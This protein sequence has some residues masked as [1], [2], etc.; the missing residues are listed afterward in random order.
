MGMKSKTVS[1]VIAVA[2]VVAIVA[3]SACS[4]SGP[5]EERSSGTGDNGPGSAAATHTSEPIVD[6]RVTD[7]PTQAL[8]PED[9]EVTAPP[10]PEDSAPVSGDEDVEVFSMEGSLAVDFQSLSDITAAS[11]VIIVG[12]V[13][14][15]K[16]NPYQ[17]IPFTVF[18]VRVDQAIKGD[19][20]VDSSTTIVETGGL[21]AG[22]SKEEPGQ[23]GKPAEA[24]FEGV[25]VM[26]VG[27]QWLL[28][29]GPY[30]PGPVATN[31]FS[32]RGVFQGK[33]RIEG[34]GKLHFTGPPEGLDSPMFALPAQLNG[35]TLGEVA[36]EVRSLAR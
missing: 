23:Y 29:L 19:L 31:A 2:S 9:T 28:F 6:D 32:V 18:T 3:V 20:K 22:R 15:A 16:P 1:H 17:N 5:K 33:M 25:R 10:S 24:A 14:D 11:A 35:R 4:S 13:V 21:I 34:D 26:A 12:T 30:D 27:E 7:G 8:V 36:D